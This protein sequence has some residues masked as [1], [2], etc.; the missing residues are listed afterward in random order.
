MLEPNSRYY[1]IENAQYH[2]PDGREIIYKK[3]RFL[4]QGKTMSILTQ[5]NYTQGDRLDLITDRTLGESKEFWRI[6]DANNTMKPS[7]LTAELGQTIL[8]PIPQI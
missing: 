4:P 5:V 6:C 2:S 7:D 3:R 1:R 8:V